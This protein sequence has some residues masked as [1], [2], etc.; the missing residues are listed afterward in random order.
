MLDTLTIYSN[1]ISFIRIISISY[2]DSL[3]DKANVNHG[4]MYSVI[5]STVQEFKDRRT[6]VAQVDFQTRLTFF[7][8]SLSFSQFLDGD[9]I[10]PII[11]KFMQKYNEPS[12]TL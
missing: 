7:Q 12:M 5:L 8:W 3:R 2:T 1:E 11:S 4:C 9:R 10:L 6:E